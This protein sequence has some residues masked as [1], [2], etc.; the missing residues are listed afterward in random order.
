P[1]RVR[2]SSSATDPNEPDQQPHQTGIRIA[3]PFGGSLDHPTTSRM[4]LTLNTGAET[5]A[6]SG[7][8]HTEFTKRF[9][10]PRDGLAG[11]RLVRITKHL[12]DG[13]GEGVKG[14]LSEVKE[15]I[16]EVK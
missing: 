12:F 2:I 10:V 1:G 13:Q 9:T 15:R 7:R 4:D 8:D 5:H 16:D 3:I 6:E 14:K 11:S